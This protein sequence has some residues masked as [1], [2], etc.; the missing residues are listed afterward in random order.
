MKKLN[1]IVNPTAGLGRRMLPATKA[2][3]KEMLPV[4]NKPMLWLKI[5]VKR[6]FV[7]AQ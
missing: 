3:P 4:L 6:Y 1:K 2:I 7:L 5:I